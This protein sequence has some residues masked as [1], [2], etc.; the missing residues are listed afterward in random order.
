MFM[1]TA[2]MIGTGQRGSKIYSS[3]IKAIILQTAAEV[4]ESVLEEEVRNFFRYG[5]GRKAVKDA[6]ARKLADTTTS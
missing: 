3:H 1:A 4:I 6:V 5:D 2:R